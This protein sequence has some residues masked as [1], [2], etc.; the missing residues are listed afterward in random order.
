MGTVWR[1]LFDARLIAQFPKKTLTYYSPLVTFL[2][3]SLSLS[4]SLFSRR[5]RCSFNIQ[6]ICIITR[7]LICTTFL[8]RLYR[9]SICRC[10]GALNIVAGGHVIRHVSSYRGGY[11]F[12]RF[13]I[14]PPPPQPGRKSRW[15]RIFAL[16]LSPPPWTA[17]GKGRNGSSA[18]AD[19]PRWEDVRR[20]SRSGSPL[21]A[22][23][24]A[25]VAVK[26]P[27]VM[28]LA[29]FPCTHNTYT[30]THTRL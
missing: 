27:S 26:R 14:D 23:R 28:P 10:S 19:A 29:D 15:L 4:L 22:R 30:H 1:R 24:R 13:F 11:R 16:A 20:C 17:V 3:I 21:D 12:Y 8:R 6:R 25:D 18:S 9:K 2:L 5:Y 7:N